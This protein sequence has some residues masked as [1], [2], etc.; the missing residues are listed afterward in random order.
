[1]SKSDSISIKPFLLTAVIVL[2]DQIAKILIV[3][4]IPEGRI[5]A[6]FFGGFLR[7]I[8]VRNLGVAFSL[9]HNL[10][11]SLRSLLFILIPLAGLILLGFF[12]FKTRELS[13]FQRWALT[14]ILGGGIGNL[15]DRIA[16][17]SG[18]VDFV[19]VK[20]YGIF[21]LSRWPTFNV[22]DASIVV[23]GILFMISLFFSVK[24]AD[25]KTA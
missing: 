15:I 18:V 6:S 1:M 19:D 12:Y 23:C 25:E 21:G 2:L 20:F 11:D 4:R 17:P 8:H 5:G 22:A 13:L 24:G 14:G 16:R 9:G 3:S 7:I 10:P